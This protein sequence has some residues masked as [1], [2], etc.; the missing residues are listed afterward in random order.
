MYALIAGEL[1][2]CSSVTQRI[3]ELDCLLSLSANYSNFIL[4]IFCIYDMISFPPVFLLVI[5]LSLF[6]L[7]TRPSFKLSVYASFLSFHCRVC[8]LC[9]IVVV[10][11]VLLLSLSLSHCTRTS[12]PPSLMPVSSPMLPSSSSSS[13]LSKTSLSSPSSS[14]PSSS[15]PSLP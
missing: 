13:S 5:A 4:S 6:P 9:P 3:T 7:L 15:L 11:F 12:F 14:S 10:V 2:A 1:Q 8:C